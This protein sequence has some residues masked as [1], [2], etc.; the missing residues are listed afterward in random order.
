MLAGA[1]QDAQPLQVR[2]AVDG[3][4]PGELTRAR[5]HRAGAMG[6]QR[7][8]VSPGSEVSDADAEPLL[9]AQMLRAQRLT[10]RHPRARAPGNPA[11][12]VAGA[13]P[14]LALRRRQQRDVLQVQP[15]RGEPALA[16]Q[17]HARRC[18][19]GGL[20]ARRAAERPAQQR[21]LSRQR[22]HPGPGVPAGL[23]Q[24]RRVDPAGQHS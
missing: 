14:A 17:A 22:Q 4:V 13:E 11:C 15:G 6:G 19:A 5:C 8:D 12:P 16:V 10:G 9:L 3:T 18:G 1:A 2:V 20:A 7:G 23:G 21:V 24:E